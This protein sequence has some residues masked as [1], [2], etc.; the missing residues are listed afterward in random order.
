MVLIIG[1][2][3]KPKSM[4]RPRSG[5]RAPTKGKLPEIILDRTCIGKGG[6]SMVYSAKMSGRDVA[7]KKYPIT[8]RNIPCLMECVIMASLS[9]P[10]INS[11]ILSVS[12]GGSIY[13]VQD[14]AT[15]DLDSYLRKYSLTPE[16]LRDWAYSI[17]KGVE[18]LHRNS[19]IH[20]DL[21]T[22]N[23]LV[24]GDKV[25]VSDFTLSTRKWYPEQEFTEEVCTYT[26]RPLENFL[27]HPWSEPLDIWSMGCT[28]YHMC[29]GKAL[30]P[31][32]NRIGE[33]ITRDTIKERAVNAIL[34]W[35][36]H[37][38]N[39]PDN[40][41]RECPRCDSRV[42]Y[43]E[44]NIFPPV[45]VMEDIVSLMEDMLRINPD[46]RC[47]ISQ[48]LA[49]SY[50]DGHSEDVGV[51]KESPH[52]ATSH[53]AVPS[54]RVST[55]WPLGTIAKIR[56]VIA[57]VD[58]PPDIEDTLLATS[59]RIYRS[60][61][62][63]IDPA[64]TYHLYRSEEMDKVEACTSLACRLLR[65]PHPKGGPSILSLELEICNTTGFMLGVVT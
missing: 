9:H 7:V 15:S 3:V 51:I 13:I 45:D 43:V 22:A 24:Y 17:A 44:N 6:Y 21:K 41:R 42:K 11:S 52:V 36:S 40:Y 8:S 2:N 58:T 50:F 20:A 26:H 23:I 34:G 29:T 62:V 16:V 61:C 5:Q 49:H 47:T 28:F 32:Q 33:K 53:P 37:G 38:P 48:I 55:Q 39:A 57:T 64:R 12:A 10:N 31:R 56:D 18:F 65:V 63:D 59:L 27:G 30:F 14:R 54:R 19:Y 25:K 1:K 60:A 46:D 35:G 4:H